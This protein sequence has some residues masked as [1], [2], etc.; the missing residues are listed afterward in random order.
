MSNGVTP[1]P[2]AATADPI[3]AALND[4]VTWS[5]DA[6]AWQSD[7]L[8]RLYAQHRLSS[9]DVAELY[10]LCR[11]VYDMLEEGEPPLT[12]QPLDASHIPA[13]WNAGGVVALK[14]IGHAKN[15]NALADDQTLNFAEIGL[16]VIY[17]DN[18]A[19]KSGYGRVLKRACRARDQEDILTNAYATPSGKPSARIKHSVAGVVQPE[20][21]WQ[22]DVAAS[23]DLSNISVFDS[24]CASVH[25]GGPNELAYTPVPLQMLQALADIVRDF[26]SRLKT[27]KSALED[28][29]PSFRKKP[30]SRDGTAVHQLIL[31]ISAATQ[32][33]AITSLVQMSD[34]EKQRLE[35]LKRDLASDPAKE[36]RKLKALKQRVEELAK[37]VTASESVLLPAKADELR[38]LLVTAKDKS[39]AA[40]LAATDAYN[41]EPLPQ[42][43][44]EVWKTLWEAACSFS[45]KEA[46]PEHPFPHTSDGAVCVLC[47]QPLSTEAAT[48][49]HEFEKFVQQKVQQAVEEAQNAVQNWRDTIKRSCVTDEAL[50][51]A[52]RLLRDELDQPALCLKAARILTKARVRG[53]KFIAATDAAFVGTPRPVASIA[54]Q[55]TEIIGHL[56][57][58]IS[59]FQKSTDP[60]QRKLQ[61]NE[62]HG[63]EDRIWLAGIQTDVA[64]EICRLKKIAAVDSAL[65]DADTSRITRKTTELSKALVTN[66]IRDAFAAETTALS[67]SDRCLEL[68]QEPS[69]YGSTKFKVSLIRNPKAKVASVLSEGEHRCIA[70]A[71]FFA[72][73]STAHNRSGVIFDDP[74]SS[75][76]HNYRE[77]VAA[78]LVKEAASGR[79]VIVFT[80]DIPFLMML[81]EEGRKQSQAP[82][83][84][85]VNRAVDRA[86]ICIPGAPF[87][88]KPV[89]DVV[90]KLDSRVATTTALH[91]NGRLD[92]WAEQV[93]AMAGILR[94]GWERAAETYVAPVAQRFINKIHPGGLR[95]L[96]ILTDQDVADL[97]QG[98]GFACTYCHTDSVALNR[99]VPTPV[100]LKDEINRLR[101]WFDS[102]HAR[103]E[104]KK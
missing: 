42:A 100:K 82:H 6:P 53:R 102:V 63:L 94:D 18:G 91:T 67:M 22:N 77:L 78:R 101:N 89:P 45:T 43:G 23:P 60:A 5:L 44:S 3:R 97:N 37:A 56:D 31:R 34:L 54:E 48:R 104:Q 39:T 35:Q 26:A 81:D 69:G 74:V 96:T 88:A 17:G 103:Q 8:R 75:L 68:T 93:K 86:G 59:E 27:K 58:R 55:V 41:R 80:H 40:L 28:Q 16:T 61:E 90:T 20:V 38:Q 84:Q 99:P 83:Y 2:A 70:L 12:A 24:K 92:E 29:V 30:L 49:L 10:I 85:S 11:Q 47:Q 13:N 66:T 15:V 4:I 46:Y 51:E 95:M 71:A 33:T 57:E 19:G 52:V 72:E 32:A 79:Q 64:V 7:A 36:I 21:A 25:V 62:L 14:S 76:D 87:K 98:Y 73:L 50:A 1:S 9:V 65:H